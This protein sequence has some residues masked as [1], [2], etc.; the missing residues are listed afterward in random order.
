M[1]TAL[2]L[3]GLKGIG[4]SKLAQVLGWL[5]DGRPGTDRK[6]KL[7]LTIDNKQH[8]YGAHNEHFEHCILLCD[9]EAIYAGDV[10]QE[11]TI[12]HIITGEN[13]FINPKGLPGRSARNYIR[14]LI[15][16]NALW[17]IPATYDERRFMVLEPSSAHKGDDVY[18]G[19][20]DDSL[21][22]P[23]G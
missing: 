17:H 4:K 20:L 19:A 7:S 3:R 9:E 13:L 23:G 12:K 21:L 8:I 16:G 2:V 18:F 1:G 6:F 15:L 11:S 22:A 10:A 5:M 14:T